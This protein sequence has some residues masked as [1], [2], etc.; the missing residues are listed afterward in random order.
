V[1]AFHSATSTIKL[2][3]KNVSPDTHWIVRRLPTDG[4][5]R[6]KMQLLDTADMDEND[7]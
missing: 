6:I 7:Y 3:L 1:G 5:K 4:G 2:V